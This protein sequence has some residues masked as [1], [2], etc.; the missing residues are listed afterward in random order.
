LMDKSIVPESAAVLKGP[1]RPDTGAIP[2]LVTLYK[3]SLL[4]A[5]KRLAFK[6]LE[7]GTDNFMFML[8]AGAT[9]E[10]AFLLQPTNRIKPRRGGKK[11][12]EIFGMNLIAT[13]DCY[14]WEWKRKTETWNFKPVDPAESVFFGIA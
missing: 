1:N 4:A 10:E 3:S 6:S 5:P 2:E 13:V 9:G 12:K 14:L 7:I 8:R 11:N